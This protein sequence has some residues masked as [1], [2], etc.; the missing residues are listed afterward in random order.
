[1]TVHVEALETPTN[2]L[3]MLG[4]RQTCNVAGSAYLA[5]P[6]ERELIQPA[7]AALLRYGARVHLTPEFG[8]SVAP[9]VD[10]EQRAADFFGTAEALYISSGYLLGLAVPT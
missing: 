2:A 4:G 9:Q 10:V 1:M 6:R 5:I 3:M 7:V 8:V